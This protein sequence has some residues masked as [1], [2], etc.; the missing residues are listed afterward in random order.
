V[1]KR[2]LSGHFSRIQIRL[3]IGEIIRAAEQG[4]FRGWYGRFTFYPAPFAG[5]LAIEPV[6]FRMAE[7]GFAEISSVC[8][9]TAT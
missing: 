7:Q 3:K 8:Q 2:L 9:K 6:A 4:S 5:S 1:S